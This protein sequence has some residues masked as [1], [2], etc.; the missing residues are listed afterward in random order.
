VLYTDSSHII[1]VAWRIKI[2][3]SDTPEDRRIKIVSTGT[4]VQAIPHAVQGDERKKQ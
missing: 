4:G 3:H 1:G 2:H